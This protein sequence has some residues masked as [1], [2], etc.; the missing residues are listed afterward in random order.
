MPWRELAASPVHARRR[1][2]GPPLRCTSSTELDDVVYAAPLRPLPPLRPALRVV[3][4]VDEKNASMPAN[5]SD[6]TKHPRDPDLISTRSPKRARAFSRPAPRCAAECRLEQALYD[7]A[8][9]IPVATVM[10]KLITISNDLWVCSYSEGTYVIGASLSKYTFQITQQHSAFSIQRPLNFIKCHF[11]ARLAR[12]SKKR[13]SGAPTI[14]LKTR[15]LR[16]HPRIRRLKQLVPSAPWGAC[17]K[18]DRQNDIFA[19]TSTR[20]AGQV[21]GGPSIPGKQTRFRSHLS[22]IL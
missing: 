17:K 16:D 1:L 2:P 8:A 3:T 12:S 6:R 18:R 4:R 13:T 20:S 19:S 11:H 21:T 9:N 14:W 10:D 7:K 5:A 15:A 22:R